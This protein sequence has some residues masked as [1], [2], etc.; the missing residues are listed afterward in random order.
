MSEIKIT[1]IQKV[2][3]SI[4]HHSGRINCYYTVTG[5]RFHSKHEFER[6]I[7]F[8]SQGAQEPDWIEDL[9][10]L[11]VYSMDMSAKYWFI[12]IGDEL[13]LTDDEEDF[14]IEK[15]KEQFIK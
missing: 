8:V 3:D 7:A 10:V 9:E 15:I 12:D 13:E 4:S 1:S 2:N 6:F 11:S 14:I 5:I